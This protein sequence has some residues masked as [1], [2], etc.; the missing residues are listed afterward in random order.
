M[1]GI[2]SDI[3]NV[4]ETEKEH[5]FSLTKIQVLKHALAIYA[6]RNQFVLFSIGSALVFFNTVL[7]VISFL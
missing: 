1:M 3:K 6:K 2:I 7:N 5:G 4:R